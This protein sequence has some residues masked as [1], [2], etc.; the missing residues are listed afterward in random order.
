MNQPSCQPCRKT[1][2]R[3]GE[4]TRWWAQMGRS[5][6]ICLEVSRGL[7]GSQAP[8]DMSE[9]RVSKQGGGQRWEEANHG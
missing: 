8:A 1:L 6:P 2:C 9:E 7:D 3:K 4:Q 5:K